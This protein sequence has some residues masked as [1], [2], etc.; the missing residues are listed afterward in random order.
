ML[1]YIILIFIIVFMVIDSQYREPM[2]EKDKLLSTI[3]ILKNQGVIINEWTIYSREELNVNNLDVIKEIEAKL[4]KDYTKFEWSTDMEQDH[5]YLF[6]GT[7]MKSDMERERITVTADKENHSYQVVQTYSYT[8]GGWSETDYRRVVNDIELKKRLY[9]TV[10]G[11]LLD[12][13]INT[14][15]NVKANLLLENL[16]ANKVEGLEEKNL[17]SVSAFNKDWTFSL[18]STNNKRFNLQV[19][20]RREPSNS[21]LQITIGIP[22]ITEEY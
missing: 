14:D 18:P 8:R 3:N 7:N 2:D 19:A 22:I 12:V 15:L 5:H 20:L 6:V 21:K 4:K 1:L 10:K 11:S 16:S 17:V 9:F 13:D